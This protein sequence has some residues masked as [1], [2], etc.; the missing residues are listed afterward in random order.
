MIENSSDNAKRI[1]P[2]AQRNRSGNRRKGEKSNISG[3]ESE[4]R[5]SSLS[6]NS[7]ISSSVSDYETNFGIIIPNENKLVPLEGFCN[8]EAMQFLSDRWM[9]T[10]QMHSDPSIDPAE[11]PVIYSGASGSSWGHMKLPHQMDFLGELRRMLIAN[12]NMPAGADYN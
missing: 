4:K 11:K 1:A 6:R 2:P 9:L 5:Q 8:S 3:V 10:M 7:S 12:T